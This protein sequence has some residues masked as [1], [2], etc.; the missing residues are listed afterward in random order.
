MLE[1]GLACE[2][3]DATEVGTDRPLSE[4][5]DGADHPERVDMGAAAEL[6]RL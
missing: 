6:T 1:R 3:L 5:G 2:R 4:H